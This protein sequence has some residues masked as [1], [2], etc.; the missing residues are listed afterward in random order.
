VNQ[1]T[2]NWKEIEGERLSLVAFV[3]SGLAA[4]VAL[5]R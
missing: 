5:D 2:Q 4:G 1:N 3:S